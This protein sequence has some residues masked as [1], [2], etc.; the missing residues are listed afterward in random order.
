MWSTDHDTFFMNLGGH[1]AV[2]FPTKN[3]K[4]KSTDEP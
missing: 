2:D 4:K 3:P 1:G